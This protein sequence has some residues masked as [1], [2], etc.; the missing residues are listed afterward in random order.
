MA[1]ITRLTITL[2][3]IC[4]QL[5]FW[6]E[7]RGLDL[8]VTIMAGPG[9][10]TSLRMRMSAAELRVRVVNDDVQ[11]WVTWHMGASPVIIQYAI[12]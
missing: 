10:V 8:P 7:P 4:P 1:A 11:K 5:D 12:R 9:A 2:K 6:T 3:Y